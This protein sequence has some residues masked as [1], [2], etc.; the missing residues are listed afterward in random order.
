MKIDLVM[1][2]SR[3]TVWFGFGEEC[4][5]SMKGELCYECSK[6]GPDS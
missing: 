3:W 6:W 2:A 5:N 1:R 4:R